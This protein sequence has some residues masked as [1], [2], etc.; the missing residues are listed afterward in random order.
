MTGNTQRLYHIKVQ[1]HTRRELELRWQADEE[2]TWVD[3]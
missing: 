2:N 3:A 1:Y